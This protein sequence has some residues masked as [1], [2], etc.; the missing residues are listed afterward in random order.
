MVKNSTGNLFIKDKKVVIESIKTK[1]IY[2]KSIYAVYPKTAYVVDSKILESSKF[3]EDSFVWIVL[4]G[5]RYLI[6]TELMSAPK[7]WIDENHFQEW[8]GKS[9]KTKKKSK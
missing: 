5:I 8:N 2:E 4:D 3:L 1:F 9:E 6:T 7:S